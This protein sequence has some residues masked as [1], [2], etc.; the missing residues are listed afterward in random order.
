M[1]ILKGQIEMAEYT[2]D[3]CLVF[4]KCLYFEEV[5]VKHN[6]WLS[7][8]AQEI[9]PEHFPHQPF[10]D[11]LEILDLDEWDWVIFSAFPLG[12]QNLLLGTA[13]VDA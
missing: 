11:P 5:E 2:E 10:I 8:L 13:R 12:P 9:F 6:C 4:E 1:G 7:V 3:K